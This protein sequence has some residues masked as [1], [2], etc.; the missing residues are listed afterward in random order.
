MEISAMMEMFSA[1]SYLVSIS[2]PA[3]KMWPVWWETEPLIML[4]FN[5]FKFKYSY[6]ASGHCIGQ[7]YWSKELV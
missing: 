6:V 1:L 3:L 7:L 2:Y 4:H 5:E